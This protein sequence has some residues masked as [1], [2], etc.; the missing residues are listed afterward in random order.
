MLI[1]DG[2]NL[3]G[4]AGGRRGARDRVAVVRSLLP[5]ARG[6]GRV[7][8]VFDGPPDPAVA[9][10][11]GPL[12]VRWSGRESAD[13]VILRLAAARPRDTWVVTEDRALARACR[14]LGARWL[15][16]HELPPPAGDPQAEKPQPAGSVE[17][18]EEWFRRGGG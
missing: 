9:D 17:E 18:W 15:R 16:V 5:R 6:R 8:V 3:G 12:A 2:S 4:A 1:V 10:R 14:D 11:Y 13:A 7:I